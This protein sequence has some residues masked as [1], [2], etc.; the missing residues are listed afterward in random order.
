[1]NTLE[2]AAVRLKGEVQ[3][4]A[5]SLKVCTKTSSQKNSHSVVAS[6]FPNGASITVTFTEIGGNLTVRSTV[7]VKG[8]VP[9]TKY[10]SRNES[11][12]NGS[13]T[14]IE[15]HSQSANF[16]GLSE[17]QIASVGW[18]GFQMAYN[19]LSAGAF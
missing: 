13:V 11:R 14:A 1:M 19:A 3:K 10:K 17:V 6:N 2:L 12:C 16:A 7:R 5:P 8:K 4:N 15:V 9:V 18:N